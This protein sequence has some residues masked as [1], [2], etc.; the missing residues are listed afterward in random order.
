M[1][2][3]LLVRIVIVGLVVAL[4]PGAFFLVH[5]QDGSDDDPVVFQAQVDVFSSF[6]R[7]APSREADRVAS[8]FDGEY[9]EVVG[10][11]LD[12]TWFE[13]RR[14][15]RLTNLGWIFNE[16]VDWEF[17]PER[18]PLTDMITGVVGPTPLAENPGFAV[19]LQ[20]G[21]V[22]REAPMREAARLGSV[23]RFATVPVLARNQ[24]GSWLYVNY[25]GY[26][27]W[28]IAF[29]GRDIPN[30]LDIPQ[31]PNLPPLPTINVVI[32]P[33]EVQLS[34]VYA[35]RDFVTP[36]YELAI[37]LMDFWQMVLDGEVLPCEPPASVVEFQYKQADVRELPELDRYVPQVNLGVE[38]LNASLA[39]LQNCGVVQPDDV[40]QARADAVNARILFYEGLRALDD[41]EANIQ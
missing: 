31:A 35:L 39:T 32:I 38:Y 41:L 3:N 8:V 33:P 5:A 12:G 17:E 2:H 21:V 22:L 34:H 16:M 26:E 27:G 37:T 13:V 6:V 1:R 7:A 9:L 23:P 18:L 14:P 11:N 36:R 25:L 19:H 30:V 20:S 15:G 28:I 10:R 40:R 4:L 29:T 24:D